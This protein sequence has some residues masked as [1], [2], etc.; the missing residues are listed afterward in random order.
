MKITLTV[1]A[2]LTC[3]TPALAQYYERPYERPPGY[4]PGYDMNRPPPGYYPDRDRPPQDYDQ[5]R[6]RYERERRRDDRD[7]RRRRVALGSHCE[8]FVRTDYSPQRLFCPIVRAK[9]LGEDCVCPGGPDGSYVS[10]RT[11][12]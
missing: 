7:Y 8:A 5:D 3:A 2:A 10:G 12:P 6:P 9:P 1:L 4:E 11:V